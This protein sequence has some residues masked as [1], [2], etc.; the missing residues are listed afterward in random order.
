MDKHEA[1]RLLGVAEHEILSV[2]H[3]A[4]GWW[5]HHEDMASHVRTWRHIPGWQVASETA[6]PP[7]EPAS[8]PEE[9]A[10]G[11][12]V[13]VDGD[14]V[15]DGTASQVLEWVGD[16]PARAALALA[17][18]AAR[19]KPRILLSAALEKLAGGTNANPDS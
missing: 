19:D 1:A 3:D 6:S 17:A 16:D 11:P 9:E 15:P 18:E 12:A 4:E 5:A 7:E 10:T 8:P 2:R 14:G 13:D